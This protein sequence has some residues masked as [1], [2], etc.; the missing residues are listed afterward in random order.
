[1]TNEMFTNR[2]GKAIA[3]P[4]IEVPKDVMITI[5]RLR[6]DYEMRGQHYSLTGIL[7]DLIDRG[8]SAIR[9]S[10]NYAEKSKNS[11]EFAKKAVRMFDA[12][13]NIRDPEALRLLAVEHNLVKG[14]RLT[15][16]ASPTDDELEA[17]TAPSA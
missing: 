1:M 4:A 8:S 5:M 3:I 15:P 14:L 7:I 16:T 9:H 12:N 2:F 10:W 17:A 11:R 6:E 13:G